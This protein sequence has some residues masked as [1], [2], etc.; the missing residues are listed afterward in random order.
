M[1]IHRDFL[2]N[3]FVS[4]K[5]FRIGKTTFLLKKS[6]NKTQRIEESDIAVISI[7]Q[8]IIKFIIRSYF[9]AYE[10]YNLNIL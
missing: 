5:V 1:N 7:K 6:G 2:S 8:L 9:I 10:G 3:Y 4:F